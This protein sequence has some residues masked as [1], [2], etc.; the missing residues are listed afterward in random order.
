[1]FRPSAGGVQS[2]P[3]RSR[4]ED[5]HPR[6]VPVRSVPQAAIAD[7]VAVGVELLADHASVHPDLPAFDLAVAVGVDTDRGDA[8]VLEILDTVDLPVPVLV[9]LP[10]REVALAVEILPGVRLSVPRARVTFL[11]RPRSE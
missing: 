10:P 1:M 2:W 4:G 5:V 11:S 6:E 8:S 7:A 3:R 9:D